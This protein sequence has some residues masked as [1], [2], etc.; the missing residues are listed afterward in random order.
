AGQD[1]EDV[2]SATWLDAARNLRSF[3]GTEDDFRGWLFSIA[4]RRLIDH[5]R[6]QE[7]RPAA[8]VDHAIL[9]EV[10]TRTDA[11]DDALGGMGDAAARQLVAGLP[12]EQADIV[13]LRVVA[14]LTVDEVAAITGR[15]PGTV[16][17]LQHRALR[18]LA[19]E[20]GAQAVTDERP[21]AK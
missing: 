14:G 10:G 8:A 1:A 7:R 17:V 15:R 21:A 4:R 12:A 13:L 16:R 20:L 9:A 2:A 6:R 5:L 19:R 11:A 18:R 3:A